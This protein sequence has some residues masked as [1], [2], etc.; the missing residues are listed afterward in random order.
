MENILAQCRKEKTRPILISSHDHM[1]FLLYLS[2]SEVNS[3]RAF[4]TIRG[5]WPS[6]SPFTSLLGTQRKQLNWPVITLKWDVL[7]S[8]EMEGDED[9]LLRA[10]W[11]PADSCLTS[12][13]QPY[14]C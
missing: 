14:W 7:W 10:S 8:E 1:I 12:I 2:V 6:V 4:R 13:W 3:S 5:K 9:T 11:D